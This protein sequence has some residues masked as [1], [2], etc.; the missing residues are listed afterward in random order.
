MNKNKRAYDNILDA[1]GN[2]PLVRLNQLTNGIK[3]EIYAK[4]EFLNPMGSIKDRIA[5]YMIEKAEREGHLKNGQLIVENSSGNT[6]L[7]LAL[8]AVQ[9]GYKLKVVVRDS[10]SKEKMDQ[11]KSMGVDILKVDHTLPPESPDSYNNIT[12]RIAEETPGCFFPD[13]HNNRENNETH[14]K[15]TGP[16]IWEQMNGRIDYFV[17]GMGT[18]GTIGGVARFLKEKD[19]HIKIIAVDPEGSIFYDYF[20]TKKLTKPA[21]YLIEGLGDE[22]LIGCADFS[23]IDDM[24]RVTDKDAFRHARMLVKKEGVMGGGSSGA[25]LWAVLKLAR[26]LEKPARI[27]TLFPDSASRYLSTIFN[28]EWMKS[29]GLL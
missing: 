25:A 10:L 21:P 6:A 28:D 5:K 1:I 19:P 9:K 13:Q 27:V 2:T 29:K 18:G 14:Y 23:N 8:V 16:E 22:F 11:L 17:A 26:S 12:P 3:S 7:G 4:L 20:Y 24:Y 15:T